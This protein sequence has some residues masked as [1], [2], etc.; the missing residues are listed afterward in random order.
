VLALGMLT[1]VRKGFD[2]IRQTTG[3]SWTMATLPPEDPA[4]YDMLCRADA[5]GVFQVE[6]RA[7]L[8]MLP[9]LKPR[10]YYD[11]V[12]EVAIV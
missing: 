1:A 11:L 10:T 8:N 12:I 5:V 7:Q 4:V 3:Q 9:R 6:S 2:L